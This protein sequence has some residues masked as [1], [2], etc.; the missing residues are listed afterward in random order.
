MNKNTFLFY[1]HDIYYNKSLNTTYKMNINI[2][3]E[4]FNLIYKKGTYHLEYY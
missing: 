1:N 4:K 3:K 2:M